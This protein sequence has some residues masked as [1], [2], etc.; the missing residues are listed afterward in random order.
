MNYSLPILVCVCCVSY[1]LYGGGGWGELF[2]R[3]EAISMHK[4]MRM[5]IE[6]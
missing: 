1:L 2:K 3:K 6:K 5:K 4:D